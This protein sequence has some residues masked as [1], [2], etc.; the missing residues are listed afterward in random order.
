MLQ[1]I[2]S[3][4]IGILLLSYVINTGGW[5][6]FL[7]ILVLNI[8][9]L[10]ELH[11]AFKRINIHV[12][13]LPG[14]ALTSALLVTVEFL[15]ALQ[16]K[17]FPLFLILILISI[18]SY[19]VMAEKNHNRFADI[20]FTIFSFIYTSIL[21]MYFIWVRNLF[22]GVYLVWWIF[23]TIWAC[24]TGAFFAGLAFGKKKLAPN[25]SPHKTVEGSAGGL[26]FSAVASVIFTRL[27]PPEISIVNAIAFSL[28]I[29][30]FSQIGDLSASLIKRYCGIKDFSNLIP[31]HG[32]VLDR[33]D[34]ALFSFPVAYYYIIFF[35]QKG[36]LR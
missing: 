16:Y 9:A 36:G 28:L 11:N 31:G 21:F 3:A 18:F 7:A 6:F 13:L 4:I 25:I 14:A 32:G 15:P 27:V 23:I 22:D 19:N 26:F 5:V 24:D 34:S 20:V 33:F 35:L 12:A 8:I 30:C 29:G 17:L 10:C 1:R 2:V